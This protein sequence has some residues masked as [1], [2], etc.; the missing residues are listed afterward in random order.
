MSSEDYQEIYINLDDSGKLT[1]NEIVSVYAGI[2]FFSKESKDKF[3]TQYRDIINKI[4]CKYCSNKCDKN[5]IEIK[6]TNIKPNDKRRIINYIKKYYNVALIID[7]RNVYDYIINNKASKGR[8][9]DYCIRRLIKEIIQDL[10]KK[11]KINPNNNIKLIINIDQQTTKSN[12]YYTLKD[13]I[14]EELLYGIKN[15]DYNKKFKPILFNKLEVKITYQDSKKS[16][17]IQASDIL[18]GTVRKI[19]KDN[20]ENNN[21]LNRNLDIIN[22]ELFLP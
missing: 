12:G 13:G 10:I 2:V 22:Y 18:A 8:Y 6:N 15:Y 16:Y 19:V 14:I 3:I 20:I 1:R 5:C 9:T 4:K 11:K 7:N 21:I 17:T